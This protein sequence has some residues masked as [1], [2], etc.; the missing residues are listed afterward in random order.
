MQRMD[1]ATTERS[2]LPSVGARVAAF[3]IILLSGVAGGFI[4]YSFVDLQ[5]EGDC[6]AQ[7]GIGGVIGAVIGAGGVAVVVV[8]ALRAMSEWKTIQEREAD[9][10]SPRPPRVR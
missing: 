1:E 4:G 2:A 3:A 9:A 6:T 7:T 8:L 5:C 10:E